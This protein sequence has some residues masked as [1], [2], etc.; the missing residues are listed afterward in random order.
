[1]AK[2]RHKISTEVRASCCNDVRKESNEKVAFSRQDESN[3]W[4]SSVRGHPWS[5]SIPVK[6]HFSA[7]TGII[8]LSIGLRMT[9]FHSKATE[10]LWRGHLRSCDWTKSRILTW[11][12]DEQ[13]YDCG[14]SGRRTSKMQLG[15]VAWL[16]N[17]ALS[18]IF[19]WHRP[20]LKF[21]YRRKS[22]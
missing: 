5:V 3:M 17:T 2:I 7:L 1:M 22:Q 4:D 16:K 21:L 11:V 15:P 18:S 12:L 14:R 19:R 13:R 8:L 6:L 9:I 20:N 10:R